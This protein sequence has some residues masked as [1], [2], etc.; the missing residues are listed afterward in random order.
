MYLVFLSVSWDIMRSIWMFHEITR[1]KGKDMEK[2][3]MTR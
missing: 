1:E 3:D 2:G